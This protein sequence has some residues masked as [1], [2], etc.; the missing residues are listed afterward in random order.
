MTSLQSY[1]WDYGNWTL[2]H[3]YTH[4]GDPQRWMTIN[5]WLWWHTWNIFTGCFGVLSTIP[6]TVQ[7]TK[8]GAIWQRFQCWFQC[9]LQ[10]QLQCR[11]QCWIQCQ[12]HYQLQCLLHY[13][14]QSH[15][16]VEVRLPRIL[17]CTIPTQTWPSHTILQWWQLMTT[18]HLWIQPWI[19]PFQSMLP[20]NQYVIS[21]WQSNDFHKRGMTVLENQTTPTATNY[22]PG[23][24]GTK[25]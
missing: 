16:W 4:L 1:H 7:E 2:K 25:H 20:M 17:P 8:S 18:N 12:L 22:N 13:Q 9:R 6:T 23:S 3:L 15:V 10:F 11:L 24:A 5:R 19:E 21:H 14:I